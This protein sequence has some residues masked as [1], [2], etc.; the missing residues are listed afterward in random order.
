[1]KLLSVTPNSTLQSDRLDFLLRDSGEEMT[2]SLRNSGYRPGAC[3]FRISR[4]ALVTEGILFYFFEVL[5]CK[6][7]IKLCFISKHGEVYCDDCSLLHCD[8]IVLSVQKNYII[9]NII[10]ALLEP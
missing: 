9:L 2:P 8:S 4:L 1:M 3:S 6:V 7:E 5:N 10:E